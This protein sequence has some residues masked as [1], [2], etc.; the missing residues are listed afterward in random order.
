LSESASG[1]KPYIFVPDIVIEIVS[2]TDQYTDVNKRVKR[3][4]DD[5]VLL[6]W[7]VDPEIKQI[8]VHRQGSDRQI[9]L[10]GDVALTA[11]DVLPGFALKRPLACT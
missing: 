8:A 2:P 5:G 3:Y 10:S 11:E 4:L 6:V 7:V 1:D 9:N